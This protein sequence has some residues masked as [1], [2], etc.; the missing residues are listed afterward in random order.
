MLPLC[1]STP[2]SRPTAVFLF[3]QW[4]QLGSS[5]PR[6]VK[7]PCTGGAT[8][9][10]PRNS[11]TRRHVRGQRFPHALR[12]TNNIR[13]SGLAARG[14]PTYALEVRVQVALRVHDLNSC[15]RPCARTFTLLRVYEGSEQLDD[16][17]VNPGTW[18]S[19]TSRWMLGSILLH[20]IHIRL[21]IRF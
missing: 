21:G 19:L 5:K 11:L 1:I 18:D 6:N 15:N 2:Y 7:H 3:F 16:L 9:Q 4:K 10:I 13:R 12:R 14:I 8:V 17:L 20:F